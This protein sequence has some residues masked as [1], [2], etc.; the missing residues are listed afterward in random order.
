M[1][2]GCKSAVCAHGLEC[3]PGLRKTVRVMIKTLCLKKQSPVTSIVLNLAATLFTADT[4]KV[5]GGHFT[6]PSIGTH[7]SR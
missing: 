4:P 7:V 5:F 2:R 6:H 1:H 3:C